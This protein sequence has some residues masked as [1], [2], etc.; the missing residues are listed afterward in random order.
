MTE[1]SLREIVSKLAKMDPAQLTAATSLKGAI[2]DSLGMAKLDASLRSKFG[3]LDPRIHQVRTFGELCSLLIESPSMSATPTESIEP[4]HTIGVHGNRNDISVGTDVQ[5]VAS[6][7][8]VP[9][10]WEDDFYK[11]TFT[12]QEIAYAVLQPSPQASF[13]AMWCAKEAFRKANTMPG[14][15]DWQKIEVVRDRHGKPSLLVSGQPT[16]GA[17]SLSHTAEIALA[18]FVAAEQPQSDV[19]GIPVSVIGSAS[20]VSAIIAALAMIISV[21]ALVVSFVRR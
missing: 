4:I 12:S 16:A 8:V 2:G 15:L 5:S 11:Q 13:A 3:V 14:S 20:R 9:D 18:V 19:P 10:F 7:Q 6:M 1:E 21:A 17:L